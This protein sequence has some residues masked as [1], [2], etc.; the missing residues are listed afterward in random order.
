MNSQFLLCVKKIHRH[1]HND[2]SHYD[3]YR[4]VSA[5]T[6]SEA[7]RKYF[8]WYNKRVSKGYRIKIMNIILANID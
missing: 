6:L 7:K 1:R 3:D 8:D 5:E 2:I 4:L